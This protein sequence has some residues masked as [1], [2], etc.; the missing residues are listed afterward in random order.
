[1][2][3]RSLLCLLVCKTFFFLPARG[4]SISRSLDKN[5]CF[6]SPQPSDSRRKY[7]TNLSG[8]YLCL[9]L[10][11]YLF[12]HFFFHSNYLLLNKNNYEKC[13]LQMQYILKEVRLVQNR[14]ERASFAKTGKLWNKSKGT[15][16][17][18]QNECHVR[19]SQKLRKNWLNPLSHNKNSFMIFEKLEFM[20]ARSRLESTWTKRIMWS[21]NPWAMEIKQ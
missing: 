6:K 15:L 18:M 7:T 17:R 21:K 5:R 16:S 12:I 3:A 20:A 8:K 9:F 19:K 10:Y 2:F 1:M 14:S 4:F 13:R 11:H